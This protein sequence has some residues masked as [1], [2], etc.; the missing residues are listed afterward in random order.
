MKQAKPRMKEAQKNE[1]SKG[2]SLERK[3]QNQE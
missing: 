2:K 3:R 1:N